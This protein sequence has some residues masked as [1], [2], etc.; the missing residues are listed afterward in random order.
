M[1]TISWDE[2]NNNSSY[3]TVGQWQGGVFKGVASTGRDGAVAAQPKMG[4]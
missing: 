1:G 4:W 2:Y 3:W